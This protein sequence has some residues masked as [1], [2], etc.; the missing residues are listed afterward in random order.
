MSQLYKI[1]LQNFRVFKEMTDFELA[2]LTILTGANSSGKSSL[3]KALLLIG[4]NVESNS[5]YKLDF[6]GTQHNLGSF[7]DALNKKCSEEKNYIKFSS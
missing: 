1:G 6:T 4:N 5:F 2:P 7:R 3:F